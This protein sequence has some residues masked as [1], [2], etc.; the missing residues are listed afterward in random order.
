MDIGIFPDL[1]KIAKVHPIYK[2]GDRDQF[3]NYRPISVLNSFSKVFEKVIFNRLLNYINSQ[4]IISHCQYGF[5][6]NQ[7]TFMAITEMYDKISL[8]I[9]RNEYCA[10]IFIDLAKAFDTLDH[11]ILLFKLEYYGIRGITLTWFR[12]YLECRQQYVTFYHTSSALEYISYGVPQG[13]ILG[14]LLFILYVNDIV[15][16]SSILNSILFA[17]DTN[18]FYSNAKFINLISTLNVELSKLSNWFKSNKLSINIKKTNYILFGNK[19]APEKTPELTLYI[20]GNEIERVEST[21]FLGVYLDKKT[22]L[23]RSC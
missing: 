17:D 18:A 6:Q 7:A 21:K 22:K 15:N 3:I 19:H 13:S 12:S 5:R 10:G 9:D 4:N 16:C 11:N 8:A 1:L 14:P 20:H 2:S 23:E